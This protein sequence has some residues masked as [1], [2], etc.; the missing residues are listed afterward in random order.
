MIVG[1][2][3][4]YAVSVYHHWCC[5]FESRSRR[6]VQHYVIKFVSDLRQCGFSPCP[7]VSSTNKT[8][9]YD[10]TEILLKVALN[11]IKQTN[12]RDTLFGYVRY[13]TT[14]TSYSIRASFIYTNFSTMVT[15]SLKT[16]NKNHVSI[17]SEDGEYFFLLRNICFNAKK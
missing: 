1:F 5:E 3:T 4:T 17:I 10:K 11:T 13:L 14:M 6:G 2:T 9:C 16:I 7:P 12:I 15:I 8:D